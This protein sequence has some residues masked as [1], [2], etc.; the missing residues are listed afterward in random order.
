M[1]VDVSQSRDTNGAGICPPRV[2]TLGRWVHLGRTALSGQSGLTLAE[3]MVVIMV[4]GLI[5]G[6]TT[7]AYY[8]T[9]RKTDQKAAAE[10][11]KEDIR[12]VYALADA[13]EGVVDATSVRHRDE[14]RMVFHTNSDSPASC[15]KILTVRTKIDR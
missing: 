2:R 6:T 9:T 15:Y 13:G 7:I 5:I 12:K 11:M 1:E 14:Y 4:A 8:Q 10:I 3:L